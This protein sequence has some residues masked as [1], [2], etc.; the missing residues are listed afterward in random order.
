[1]EK[2]NLSRLRNYLR[3]QIIVL[4][5]NELD[6]V[7]YGE[8]VVLKANLI[9]SQLGESNSMWDLINKKKDASPSRNTR[10]R[11][12]QL[13][14]ETLLQKLN[15]YVTS[16]GTSYFIRKSEET[17]NFFSG[18]A[19]AVA[20]TQYE[21]LLPTLLTTDDYVVPI[22][23]ADTI[24]ETTKKRPSSDDDLIHYSASNKRPRTVP[25]RLESNISLTNLKFIT[26]CNQISIENDEDNAY[27]ISWPKKV[28]RNIDC[29]LLP[30]DSIFLHDVLHCNIIKQNSDIF[31]SLISDFVDNSTNNN[32]SNH[33]NT[34]I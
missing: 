24:L 11:K 17:Y 6:K 20:L 2:T 15:S 4:C 10:T 29:D 16:K 34:W 12:L 27:V 32:I 21:F 23:S 25:K 7:N 14:R 8:D 13:I 33:N 19:T 26:K 22:I 31:R 18:N 28:Y 3:E 9:L 5:K 1:M 30:E